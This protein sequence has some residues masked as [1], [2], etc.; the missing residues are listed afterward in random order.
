M[1]GSLTFPKIRQDVPRKQTKV[2]LQEHNATQE[3]ET[4]ERDKHIRITT[5]Q[6]QQLASLP[7]GNT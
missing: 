2:I 7:A 5:S 6:R 4:A 3:E 1:F